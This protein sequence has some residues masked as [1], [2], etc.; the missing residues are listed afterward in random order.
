MAPRENYLYILIDQVKTMFDSYA[1]P[2]KLE[3]Y[4]QMWF[5][6]NGSALKWNLPIGVQFDTLVGHSTKKEQI[7]WTLTFHYKGNPIPQPTYFKS[8]LLAYS[9]T[10]IHSLK[11]SMA[12]RTGDCNE[13]LT[14]LSKHEEN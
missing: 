13:I 4:D 1:P 9:Y 7:P 14:H 8:P 2:E 12:L 5:E 3:S 10:F 6:F 11:E